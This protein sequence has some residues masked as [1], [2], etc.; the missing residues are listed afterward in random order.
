MEQEIAELRKRHL[1]LNDTIKF[2]Q[3]VC[4]G[5]IKECEELKKNNLK[6]LVKM[7]DIKQIVMK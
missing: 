1:Q 7:N 6:L 4:T 5:Y 2:T 3:G